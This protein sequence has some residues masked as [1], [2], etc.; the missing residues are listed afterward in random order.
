MHRV[1]GLQ[2]G[3]YALVRDASRLEWLR[4][5]AC[6]GRAYLWRSVEGCPPGLPLFL[7]APGSLEDAMATAALGQPI[8]RDGAVAAVIFAE[9]EPLLRAHGAW[10][11]RRMLWEACF[12][13]HAFW[14]ATEAIGFRAGAIGAFFGQWTHETFGIDCR[15]LRD[16]YHF[17]FGVPTQAAPFGD[18]SEFRPPYE[19]LEHLR[20]T[21]DRDAVDT[22]ERKVVDIHVLG[23]TAQ[24]TGMPCD[25]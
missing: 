7:L 6:A 5:E 23:Q 24:R 10:M 17:S 14:L 3:L 21:R 15:G 1:E 4:S 12:V 9:Y 2:P 11:L 18:T 22:R 20:G 8:A 25:W 13:G 19:H 16:L